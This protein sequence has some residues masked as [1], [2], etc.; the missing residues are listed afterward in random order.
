MEVTSLHYVVIDIGIVGN[1]DTSGITMLEDVQ[2]NVDRKGL[3]FVIANPRSKM[4]KKLTKSKFTKKVS[5]EWL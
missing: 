5:T 4:I 1:I 2:K 3:K